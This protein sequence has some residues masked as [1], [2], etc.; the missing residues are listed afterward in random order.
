MRDPHTIIIGL[1]N[2][3]IQRLLKYRMQLKQYEEKPN[4]SMSTLIFPKEYCLVILL[5]HFPVSK[6]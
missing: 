6:V 3:Q 5:S 1:K 2:N 4:M